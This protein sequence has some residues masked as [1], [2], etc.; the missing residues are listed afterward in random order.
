MDSA[1]YML[2][3]LIQGE[4]AVMALVVTLS[5]VAVQLA[6][7]SYSARVIEVFRRTPDLWIL[8]LIYGFS[9]FYGLVVL[10]LIEKANPLLN[11]LS[12]LEMHIAFSYYLGVFAFVALVPYIHNTLNLLKPST[13][14]SMLSEKITK[15]NILEYVPS[16]ID[17]IN[18]SS[19]EDISG[20]NNED[21]ILPIIDII[22]GSLMKYDYDTSRECLK[23]IRI[24]TINI[25]KSDNLNNEDFKKILD[26]FLI[27][28]NYIGRLSIYKGD[29]TSVC[30]VITWFFNI[31]EILAEKQMDFEAIL[32]AG[33][34]GKIGELSIKEKLG[35]PPVYAIHELEKIGEISFKR[36]MT[37]LKRSVIIS[38]RGIGETACETKIRDLV[39]DLL[40]AL[41]D[42]LQKAFEEPEE[43]PEEEIFDEYEEELSE[44][45]ED[46]VM[47]GVN[48]MIG[49][50]IISFD[51]K[52]RD[53]LREITKFLKTIKKIA[54][55][56]KRN[57]VITIIND[58]LDRTS[59][60]LHNIF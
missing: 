24:I 27:H 47:L 50:G 4:F 18:S 36:E 31:T 44:P 58:F 3:A 56:Y 34:I 25:L 32:I 17:I 53:E 45:P 22:T 33:S 49:I 19:E 38:L 43:K 26:L 52:L 7:Q 6:A 37:Y 54:G 13:V 35:V 1:R 23:E 48:S 12:N 59:Q 57:D 46:L 21:P 30:H 2:S 15:Q 8:I 41:Y 28:F 9:I 51:Q 60:D 16:K 29:E 11:N 20:K 10:K 42:I 14:I 39:F 55:K 40:Y 5:I